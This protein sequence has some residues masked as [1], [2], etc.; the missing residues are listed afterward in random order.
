[1]LYLARTFHVITNDTFILVANMF[2]DYLETEL[3]YVREGKCNFQRI[4]IA[5]EISVK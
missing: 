5:R 3:T 4:K 2:C 1:M